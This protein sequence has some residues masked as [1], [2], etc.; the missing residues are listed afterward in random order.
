M[1]LRGFSHSMTHRLRVHPPNQNEPTWGMAPGASTR[2]AVFTVPSTRSSNRSVSWCHDVALDIFRLI[3]W[4]VEIQSRVYI[5]PQ[6]TPETLKKTLFQAALA[7]AAAHQ[8]RCLL[9]RGEVTYLSHAMLA[10]GPDLP[11]L[12]QTWRLQTTKQVPNTSK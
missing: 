9:R 2:S 1:G 12:G 11:S 6:K 7:Q 5:T 8:R 4:G 10:A 3:I